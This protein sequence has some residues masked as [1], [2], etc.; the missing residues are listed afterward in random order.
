MTGQQSPE[1]PSDHM[2]VMAALLVAAVLISLAVIVHG[3]YGIVSD[4]M[5]GLY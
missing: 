1:P 5:Q 3:V 4:L 2:V